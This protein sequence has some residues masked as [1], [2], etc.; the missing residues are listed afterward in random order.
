M[1][2]GD[3]EELGGFCVDHLCHKYKRLA[4]ALDV[5]EHLLL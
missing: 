4:K 5:F 2:D 1:A 3:D